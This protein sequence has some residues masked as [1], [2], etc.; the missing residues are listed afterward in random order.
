MKT[1]TTTTIVPAGSVAILLL[2]V[3]CAIFIFLI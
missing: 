2:A 3:L 1:N